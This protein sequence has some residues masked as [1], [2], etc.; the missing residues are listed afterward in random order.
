M[1]ANRK[2]GHHAKTTDQ[3]LVN[4]RYLILSYV[5]TY[6]KAH[7]PIPLD[8]VTNP[9]PERLKLTIRRLAQ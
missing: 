2:S 8:F 6:D 4:K 9:D 7:Y 5:S 3:R 1:Q